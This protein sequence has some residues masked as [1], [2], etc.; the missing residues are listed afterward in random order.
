[1]L[2]HEPDCDEESRDQQQGQPVRAY[3]S[4]KRIQPVHLAVCRPICRIALKSPIGGCIIGKTIF[5]NSFPF[6]S[7]VM[8]ALTAYAAI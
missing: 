2:V 5:P 8:L 7:K 6:L 3:E 4:K 1:M